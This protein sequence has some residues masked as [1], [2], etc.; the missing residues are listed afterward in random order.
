MLLNKYFVNVLNFWL[1]YVNRM[2]GKNF[3]WNILKLTLRYNILDK[4]LKEIK[5][6]II[7]F[8]HV[9]LNSN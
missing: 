6:M 1:R 9:L 2:S 7:L 8:F 5:I 3:L 4:L